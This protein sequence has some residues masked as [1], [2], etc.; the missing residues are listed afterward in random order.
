MANE[1]V[2]CMDVGG[3]N[4][5]MGAFDV[6]T[7][8]VKDFHIE[9]T[10]GAAHGSDPL[11]RIYSLLASALE[12]PGNCRGIAIGVPALVD[13]H[14]GVISHCIRIPEFNGL[15]LATDIERRYGVAAFVAN[16][17][18]L[19]AIGE[20][21]YGAGRGYAHLVCLTIGTG[22]G[23]GIIQDGRLMTGARGFAGEFGELL[24]PN[25][26]G[27]SLIKLE[28]CVAAS[29]I[30]HEARRLIQGAGPP[31]LTAEWVAEAVWAGRDEL[32]PVLDAVGSRLG[33]I[34]ANIMHILN[35]QLVVIGGGVARAGQLILE[36]LERTLRRHVLGSVGSGVQVRLAELGD[37]AG[38]QGGAAALLS[39]GRQ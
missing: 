36:P 34:V 38:L 39:A 37:E 27:D 18:Q 5:R 1:Y 11:H 26:A 14:T 30:V 25:P 24:V 6:T 28:S 4:L 9:P 10:R 2:I 8:L 29:A 20:H 12:S 17:A 3:T 35:P 16:D 33:L 31:D 23:G 19:A 15:A 21:R 32:R 13:S 22:M 7:G